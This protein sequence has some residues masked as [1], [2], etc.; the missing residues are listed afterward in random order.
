MGLGHQARAAGEDEVLQRPELVVPE[1]DGGFQSLYL[2]LFEHLVLRHR[3][4]AAEV[5]QAVLARLQ[6][7][8]HFAQAGP[9][10]LAV[11]QLRQQQAELAVQRVHIADGLDPWMVL[12]HPAVAGKPGLA[13]VPGAG[14]DLRKA[15]AHFR[16]LRPWRWKS[17]AGA[18]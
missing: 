12:R 1:V 4:L 11:G 6:H 3:Q 16:F 13:L 9:L 18:R 5:E 17:A 8:D 10:D 2:R 7:L 15:V 14:V